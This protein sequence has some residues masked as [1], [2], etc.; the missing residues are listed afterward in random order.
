MAPKM[1][2]WKTQ[3]DVRVSICGVCPIHK[4]TL[5]KSTGSRGKRGGP[6]RGPKQRRKCSELGVSWV[7]IL[8]PPW[9]VSG[10]L[11]RVTGQV[12][13]PSLE[14]TAPKRGGFWGLSPLTPWLLAR[15]CLCVCSGSGSQLARRKYDETCVF[16]TVAEKGYVRATQETSSSHR[17]TPEHPRTRHIFASTSLT[18]RLCSS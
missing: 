6:G 15:R 5:I 2:A 4:Q 9:N 13:F 12:H 3:K 11:R 16:Y 8:I 10:T 14:H 7:L 17:R 18:S 1:K